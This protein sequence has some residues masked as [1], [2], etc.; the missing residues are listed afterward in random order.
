M[1][2]NIGILTY[3]DTS[4]FGATLQAFALFYFLKKN[5]FS[6]KLIDYSSKAVD[7]VENPQNIFYELHTQ[8]TLRMKLIK[9]L[10]R[11]KRM[12]KYKNLKYFLIKHD[13]LSKKYDKKNITLA[14]Q[15]FSSFIVGSDM[16]WNF[17]INKRDFCYLLNFVDDNKDKYSYASSLG[18]EWSEDIDNEVRKL[19]NRFNKIAIREK[20]FKHYLEN[21]LG[22]SVNVVCDPTMLLDSKEWAEYIGKKIFDNYVLVYFDSSDSKCLRDA[23]EY[24]KNHNC[25]VKYISLEIRNKPN[26]DVI[27]PISIEE[28]LSLIKYANAVFTAS[29]HGMLFSAYFQKELFWYSRVQNS[30]MK[31]ISEKLGLNDRCGSEE[32]FSVRSKIDYAN[33]QEK[34]DDFRNFSSKILL[35]CFEE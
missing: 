11:R 4:N 27:F 8:T 10:T 26:Y 18:E 33:V 2:E 9:I 21:K 13:S 6:C 1:N 15:E 22:R 34:I 35:S 28:F 12:Q 24:A 20:Q 17:S 19:L 25:R 5:D 3:Q 31:F 30:R 7:L 32:D 16:T 23:I 14:N 29:Y